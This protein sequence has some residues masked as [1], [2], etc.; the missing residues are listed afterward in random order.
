MAKESEFI[1]VTKDGETIEISPLALA[2][3]LKLGWSLLDED[4]QLAQAADALAAK[5][6]AEADAVAVAEKVAADNKAAIAKAEA[7]AR[8][9]RARALPAVRAAQKKAESDAEIARKKVAK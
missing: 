9:A 8:A 4:T 6:K 2:D 5:E 3:H 7:D 1:K